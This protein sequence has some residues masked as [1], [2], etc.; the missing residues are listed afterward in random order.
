M[1]MQANYATKK[2]LKAAVGE[3]LRYSETSFF[4]PEYKANGSFCVC[5]AK[6]TW[7]AEVTMENGKIKRVS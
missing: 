2:A 7:F 6:R 1:T 3:S 5:N 4:G